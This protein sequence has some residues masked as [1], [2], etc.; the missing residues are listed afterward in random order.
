MDRGPRGRPGI[1]SSGKLFPDLCHCFLSWQIQ[2]GSSSQTSFGGCP[3]L[4]SP[5]APPPA[6][7][8]QNNITS[9]LKGNRRL[10]APQ[11]QHMRAPHSSARLTLRYLGTDPEERAP[12]PPKWFSLQALSPLRPGRRR[13]APA[14]QL[15]KQPVLWWSGDPPPRISQVRGQHPATGVPAATRAPA[16]RRTHLQRGPAGVGRGR[17][18]PVG[19]SGTAQHRDVQREQQQ[20]QQQQQLGRQ[21]HHPPQACGFR[22]RRGGRRRRRRRRRRRGRRCTSASPQFSPQA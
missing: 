4:R 7:A 3:K 22:T 19:G 12:G 9:P 8:S 18:R 15:P 16:R 6:P 2:P 1:L 14:K 11:S 13:V 10:K 20:P 5:P 17:V 21:A